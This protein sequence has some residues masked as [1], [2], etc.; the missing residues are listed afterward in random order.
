VT[1]INNLEIGAYLSVLQGHY[2]IWQLY[3][4]L[5]CWRQATK[6]FS[7]FSTSWVGVNAF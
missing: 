4:R 1:G 5:F 7:L 6:R 3:R 2:F